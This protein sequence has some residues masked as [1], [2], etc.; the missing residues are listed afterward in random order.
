MKKI[1]LP[2][3]IVLIIIFGTIVAFL[4]TPEKEYENNNNIISSSEKILYF[5]SDT[6]SYCIKQKPIIEE[7]T[8]EGVDFEYMDVGKNQNYWNDYKIEG[9]PSFIF[10]DIKLSGY[11]SKDKLKS[12]WEENK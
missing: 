10:K 1:I 4:A 8:E 5:Y 7:L 6:C 2:I 3:F 12:L 9:T 11:Q